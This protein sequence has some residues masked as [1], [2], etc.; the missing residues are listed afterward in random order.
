MTFK[1]PNYDTLTPSK[2]AKT[3]SELLDFLSDFNPD[4]AEY[5]SYLLRNLD[6]NKIQATKKDVNSTL[7]R[8]NEKI[9]EV[10][11]RIQADMRDEQDTSIKHYPEIQGRLKQDN[12]DVQAQDATPEVQTSVPDFDLLDALDQSDLD[13]DKKSTKNKSKPRTRKRLLGKIFDTVSDIKEIDK[14]PKVPDIG[15]KTNANAAKAAKDALPELKATKAATKTAVKS[16]VIDS[17]KTALKGAATTG[18]ALAR[19]AI[20]LAGAAIS[21]AEGALAYSMA[22]N[23]AQRVD[24]ISENAGAAAGA[25]IGAVIG[26][27]IP[28]P[29]VGTV[30]GAIA[31][32]YLG[33]KAG[34]LL[35]T[36]LKDPEDSIPDQIKNQGIEAEIQYIDNDLIPRIL[37]LDN[38]SEDEKQDQIKELKEYKDELSAKLA[39]S[40]TPK[41][42][43]DLLVT[44]LEDQGV[45]ETNIL[46]SDEVLNW[47]QVK[48]LPQD[49]LEI[50][51]RHKGFTQ[52]DRLRIQDILY[53]KIPD[54]L[55]TDQETVMKGLEVAIQKQNEA[56]QQALQ[57]GNK[58][59]I[60]QAQEKLQELQ[61]TKDKL[62]NQ[63]GKTYANIVETYVDSIPD[64]GEV[65]PVLAQSVQ[66]S[67]DGAQVQF[68]ASAK[69][70]DMGFKEQV[71]DGTMQKGADRVSKVAEYATK[72]A[73]ATSQGRCALFIRQALQFGGKFQFTPQP[74]A[75]LYNN[76]L[77]GLGFKGFPASEP[78]K[79]GDVIVYGRSSLHP[80]GHIQVWNGKNWVSDFIQRRAVPYRLGY[81]P[82]QSITLYRYNEASGEP[83][84]ED[85]RNLVNDTKTDNVSASVKTASETPEISQQTQQAQEVQPMTEQAE[86]RIE[87]IENQVA[88]ASNIIASQ[89]TQL[90]QQ[91]NVT[92]QMVAQQ[93]NQGEPMLNDTFADEQ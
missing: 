22:E 50:L 20:P 91:V 19:G 44:R 36:L 90:S 41:G 73:R 92:N 18:K 55:D 8:T 5:V 25:A 85:D 54:S 23:D 1:S 24:A 21:V 87:D 59:E 60:Q 80:H 30:L 45:I 89:S 37:N 52:T 56:V 65:Q 46:G 64:A 61:A 13:R 6:Q 28:I 2:E 7:A 82:A 39:L 17:S 93:P 71:A 83:Q 47:D 4:S 31:G 15:A 57:R 88:Q 66:S 38:I 16:A 49:D 74:S 72:Q 40:K 78:A 51:A 34:S 70:G 29:G 62:L 33:R 42:K 10:L 48:N 11:R 12:T 81:D 26:S 32:E 43:H 79:V 53:T 86:T 67:Y 3:T 84:N 76:V 77:P 35:G 27:F 68:D 9:L 58:V 14:K 75:Y 69:G 63:R